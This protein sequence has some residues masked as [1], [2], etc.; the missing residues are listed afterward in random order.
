MVTEVSRSG[1]GL[2]LEWIGSDGSRFQ[3]EA[4]DNLAEA[5][6]PI[7]PEL[8]GFIFVDTASFARQRY[9]RVA[10]LS[11]KKPFETASARVPRSNTTCSRRWWRPATQKR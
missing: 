3:L 1:D 9:Y 8:D 11:L 6:T 7:S 4:T 5:F 2:R 10:D